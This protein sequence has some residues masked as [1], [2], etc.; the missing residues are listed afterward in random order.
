MSESYACRL[1]DCVC[2]S[3]KID[4]KEVRGLTPSLLT[5]LSLEK[6]LI[7]NVRACKTTFNTCGCSLVSYVPVFPTHIVYLHSVL[8][9]YLFESVLCR[10]TDR[11]RDAL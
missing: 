5:L 3:L 1:S 7:Q 2:A 11:R 4:D 6:S 9:V 10:Q 8:C